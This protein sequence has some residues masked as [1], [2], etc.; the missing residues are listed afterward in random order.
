MDQHLDGERVA[1][2]ADGALSRAERASVEAHA[3]DCPRCMQL[4]AA[5]ARTQPVLP[6]RTSPV[7]IFVKWAVP[8]AAAATALALWVNVS[9]RR[10]QDL[11]PATSVV[12]P[13][14]AATP[15]AK[16]QV[17]TPPIAEEPAKRVPSRG[18]EKPAASRSQA[19]SR[20]ESFRETAAAEKRLKAAGEL[21]EKRE[22]APQRRDADA[23]RP[24]AAY[25]GP[26]PQQAP[27]ASAPPPP[28]SSAA[29]AAAPVPTPEAP[30]PTP[31]Q[32]RFR[33]A[34]SRG[35]TAR[36]FTAPV[37][38]ISPDPLR[39]WRAMGTIVQRSVDGG[40]SWVAQS[41]PPN[42]GI[43]AG[44]SPSPGVVWLAGRSGV[45]LRTTDGERWQR[46]NLPE[47]VDL[48][49]VRARNEREAD[50]TTVDGRV[51]RTLDGG[52][53]WSPVQAPPPYD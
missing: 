38:V 23:S 31:E 17:R 3:A 11:Q 12:A 2:F 43:V 40:K 53:T 49:A 36:Q 28:A 33:V 14:P 27:V 42:G 45:V 1:A 51:F 7:P 16:A 25:T 4:L 24:V 52:V 41:V 13:E 15:D 35:A 19:R 26:L 21:Q 34:D 10:A 39:R 44:T 29:P 47:P 22:Q 50:V 8:L 32:A 6:A 46:L 9:E 18:A 20:D 5:V 30:A 48:I 37:E